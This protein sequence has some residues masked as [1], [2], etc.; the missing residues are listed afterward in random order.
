MATTKYKGWDG[1]ANTETIFTPDQSRALQG[2]ATT[3]VPTF[4][5]AS[6]VNGATHNVTGHTVNT[7]NATATVAAAFTPATDTVELVEAFVTAFRTGGAGAAGNSAA[8]IRRARILNNGGAVSVNGLAAE[9]TNEAVAAWDC[10]INVV[11]TSVRVVVTGA[12]ATNIT[13]NVTLK[14]YR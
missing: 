13:W 5:G 1:S 8:Y 7:T 14:R 4:A 12:A 11:G 9:F 6:F 3:D 10:T 2:L